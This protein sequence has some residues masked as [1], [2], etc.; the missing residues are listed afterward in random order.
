M[1]LKLTGGELE[2]MKRALDQYCKALRQ[3]ARPHCAGRSALGVELC[4]QRINA[5]ALLE[6]LNHPLPRP[7]P[8]RLE[9]VPSRERTPLAAEQA[10]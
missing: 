9:A 7:E 2:I 10:A 8:I 5:E 3:E 6:Q 4:I 1:V